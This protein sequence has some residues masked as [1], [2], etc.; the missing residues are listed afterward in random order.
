MLCL[1][2]E[3][4]GPFLIA[5]R[6]RRP[7]SG[8]TTVR[9]SRCFRPINNPPTYP[10]KTTRRGW[11]A[12]AE[13]V[14]QDPTFGLMKH[15]QRALGIS[16]ME[17]EGVEELMQ[18]SPAAVR[19]DSNLWGAWASNRHTNVRLIESRSIGVEGRST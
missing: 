19:C 17:L 13:T 7:P 2:I 12:F 11:R 18:D 9:S 8:R 6:L 3:S 5:R 10:T 1:F 15:M 16:D 14:G 4:R